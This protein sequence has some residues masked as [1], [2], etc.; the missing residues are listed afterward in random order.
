M[1]DFEINDPKENI[2]SFFFFFQKMARENFVEP[3]SHIFSLSIFFLWLDFE[4]NSQ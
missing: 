2:S 1:I 3:D 4:V